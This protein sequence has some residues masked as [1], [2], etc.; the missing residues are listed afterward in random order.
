MKNDIDIIISTVK[1]PNKNQARR[2]SSL[3]KVCFVNVDK[4]EVQ[5]DFYHPQALQ[6][7]AYVD[8]LLV[9]WAGV[10][11]TTQLYCNQKIKIG[12]Y[13]ICTDPYWQ[14]KGIASKIVT[15]IMKYLSIKKCDIGFLSVNLKDGSSLA[16]HKKY[17]FVMMDQK[18]SWTDS[19]GKVKYDTGGMI[20]QINSKEIFNLVLNGNEPLFVGEGYW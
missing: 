7:L 3:Q 13:G 19:K 4:G 1:K 11:I 2:I 8:D 14:Q 18:F 10:H 12:G 9:G 5:D 17:G 6:V 15:E 20:T 16:L